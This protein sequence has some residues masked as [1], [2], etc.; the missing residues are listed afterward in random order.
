MWYTEEFFHLWL[1]FSDVKSA[2]APFLSSERTQNLFTG[3]HCVKTICVHTVGRKDYYLVLSMCCTQCIGFMWARFAGYDHSMA[4]F[5][6]L[7]VKDVFV[8][9]WRW[10]NYVM[11]IQPVRQAIN[12]GEP[13]MT[14]RP[15]L[16]T[17]TGTGTLECHASLNQSSHVLCT[18][19]LNTKTIVLHFP[20]EPSY[21]FLSGFTC[22]KTLKIDI[23][24]WVRSQ[25]H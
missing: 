19:F 17:V 1:V 18:W 6:C 16:Y 23:W 12:L 8:T 4:F 21:K 24:I 25:D 2:L 5:C 15:C 9:R 22:M 13:E 7:T 11:G 20:I 14:S 10:T 3:E